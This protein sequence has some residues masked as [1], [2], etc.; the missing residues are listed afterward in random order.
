MDLDTDYR[1][2]DGRADSVVRAALQA[3][4]ANPA[5]AGHLLAALADARVLVPVVAVA[6]RVEHGMDKDSH[7]SSVEFVATDGRRALLAFTGTDSLAAW[8]PTARPVPRRAHHAAQAVV[9]EQM[10]ALILDIAGP[11]PVVV[12]GALLARLAVAPHDG[13]PLAA[14]L[15]RIRAAAADL[16]TVCRAEVETGPQDIVL[17]LTVTGSDP[18]LP[19]MVARLVADPMV[20][21]LLDRPLTVAVTGDL[22]PQRPVG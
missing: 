13:V 4:S 1:D 11:H 3:Y 5:S 8:D 10:D 14:A 22:S 15:E 17:R 9:T 21:L 19:G 2:D 7:M 16:P 6:D 12:D 20:A 18:D